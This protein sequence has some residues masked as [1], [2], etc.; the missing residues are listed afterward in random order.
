MRIHAVRNLR[1]LCGCSDREPSAKNAT[2]TPVIGASSYVR[3]NTKDRWP[4]DDGQAP[5]LGVY[6]SDERRNVGGRTER[7][8][9][10][11]MKVLRAAVGQSG[12]SP[13][14]RA[15]PFIVRSTVPYWLLSRD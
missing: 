6:R 12:R 14:C 10:D 7:S 15:G 1:A 13:P 3:V 8:A 4:L 5:L 11:D 2:R 9:M